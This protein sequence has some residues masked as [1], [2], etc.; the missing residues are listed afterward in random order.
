MKMKNLLLLLLALIVVAPAWGGTAK[1][2]ASSVTIELNNLTDND[3]VS[4]LVAK[5]EKN[6]VHKAAACGPAKTTDATTKIDCA[7]ADSG[8][9]G[10]LSENAPPTVLWSITSL[11]EK[12]CLPGCALM[13]CP[14][15]NG[16]TVC[17]NT[18][19]LKAC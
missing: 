16:A 2:L 1:P 14:P 6:A 8:L 19:T 4:A 17:C 18:T 15:P 10:F 5:L 3:N 13:H 12:K 9:M 7:K 11:I